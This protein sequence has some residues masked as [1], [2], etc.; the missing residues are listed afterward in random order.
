M[1]RTSPLAAIA[2]AIL[3]PAAVAAHVPSVM[4]S[5]TSGPAEAIVLDDPTLSRAIGATIST[6][7]EVDW[8]RLDLQAGDRMVLSIN[9]P[10]AV[11]AIATTF[12]LFGPGLPASDVDTETQ[13]LLEALGADGVYEF[14][15]S[16]E[17]T[18]ERHGG[19]GFIDY[20]RVRFDAPADGSY[21]VALRAL[22]PEATGKYVF[23][24]GVRE[25]FGLGA[26]AGMRDLMAFFEAPWPP[27][28]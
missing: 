8:Y 12:T 2:V 21:Y 10:D 22:D 4:D 5:E 24:P 6:P 20:G 18:L 25:E 16:T 17:P 14:E 13:A 19:L 28:A 1:R 23:A 26:I 15:P 7:G 27:E 9:A 11:G 3:L